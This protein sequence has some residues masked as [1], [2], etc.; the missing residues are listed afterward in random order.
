MKTKHI[1]SYSFID[2]ALTLSSCGKKL[3]LAPHS[4]IPTDEAL[5]TANDV[6]NAVVGAYTIIARGSLYGTNLVMVPE[7]YASPGYVQW[8]GSFGTFRQIASQN[9]ISTNADVART[10]TDA[11]RAINACNTVIEA[12]GVV[13]DPAQKSII[14]GKALFV[15]GIMYFELVRLYGLPYE[16]GGANNTPSVPIFLKSVKNFPDLQYGATRSSVAD[17]YKQAENDLTAAIGMLGDSPADLY[18]AKGMLARLYLQ[19]QEY[20][21]ALTQANDIISSGDYT[22][23]DNLEAP[24]R[25]K[26]SSEGVFE[27]RQNEQSNAGTSN[28]GLTTF[29]ASYVNNTGGLVG[30]GDLNIQD[31]FYETYDPADK[32]RTEMIYDGNGAK[33]GWFT[34]KWYGYFDNIPIV[35]LT[36]LYLTRAECNVRLNSS[37]GA[38]PLNDINLLRKR[39]GLD[40]LA[41][42]TLEDVLQERTFE[43][44]FEGYRLHDL[45]RT[46]RN[47]GTL[48]YNSPKLVY[49]VPYGE[50]SVNPE[51]GQNEGYN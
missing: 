32:R 49:P 3:D 45:K 8:T 13:S 25:V 5:E 14:N 51:L 36:E 22:L 11:Y 30:R 29:F 9:I 28:D 48:P 16:A 12:L 33:S 24:F 43:L 20:G 6:N 1:L 37:V 10:W 31:A 46:K 4:E 50:R 17:V 15:R 2:L 26:N 39:A 21:K 19:Q 44:A 42:V 41:A 18:A 35:R 23:T 40:D 47:I 38:A 27:I 34:K 7:I